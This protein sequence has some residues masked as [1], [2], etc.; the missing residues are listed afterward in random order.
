[1]KIIDNYFFKIDE[2]GIF[3]SHRKG[4]LF[5]ERVK[6]PTTIDIP[7]GHVILSVFSTNSFV[8]VYFEGIEKPLAAGNVIELEDGIPICTKALPL[9]KYENC[10]DK[11][12][13]PEIFVL[14]EMIP[15]DFAE[16]LSNFYNPYCNSIGLI[17]H[18]K[19]VP[20]STYSIK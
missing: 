7:N 8:F 20:Y 2:Q 4:Q 6:H 1:M 19:G 13:Q 18:V 10:Y 14:Y 11:S 5:F 17:F 15:H 9:L 16:E 3:H 12:I